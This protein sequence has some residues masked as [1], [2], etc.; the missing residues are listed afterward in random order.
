MALKVAYTTPHGFS[1]AEAYV[2]VN[3]LETMSKQDG[4]TALVRWFRTEEDFHG[5]KVMLNEESVTIPWNGE[6]HPWVAI[7]THLKSRDD[8]VGAIDA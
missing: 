2:R 4:I 8:F 7:Y 3:N 6:D 1:V 5:G